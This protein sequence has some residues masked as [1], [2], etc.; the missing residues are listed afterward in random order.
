MRLD[1]FDLNLLIAFDVLLIERNVTRAAQRLNMTQSAMSAALKRLRESL[2]DEILVLHGK[3]MIPTPRA[4][5]L[6]P[7][8][9]ATVHSLRSLIASATA[10]EPKT[11]SRRFRIA[12]SDYITSVLL[13]PLLGRLQVDAPGVEFEICLPDNTSSK[14]M[15]D[16]ELDLLLSPEQFISPEYPSELLFTERH[17][18]IGCSSNPVLKKPLSMED[19]FAC[20]HVAVQI[21]GRLTFIEAALHAADD[22]RHIEII[23]PSF[24]QAPW[25]VRNTSRLALMHE[26]L[27]DLL[28]E[29]LSLTVAECPLDLPTMREMMQY[30]SARANDPGLSWLREQLLAA[31]AQATPAHRVRT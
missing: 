31:A 21:Q 19:F 26:R 15:D 9:A 7:E 16:G 18:V 17:V 14:A 13:A 11:S 27:A 30:H 8:I 10:F 6:A 4:M 5:A 23:T 25:M 3:K 24:I 20:G 2:N 28:A 1:H 12:A 22:R 29:P